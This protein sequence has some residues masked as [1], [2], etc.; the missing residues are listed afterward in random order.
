MWP[1]AGQAGWFGPGPAEQS[2]AV[3]KTNMIADHLR[4]LTFAITDGALP[5][6]KGRG[7]VVRSVLRRAVRQT[8]ETVDAIVTPTTP[9][10][11]PTIAAFDS[12]YRDPAAPNNISDIRRLTL[13]NTSPFNKYGLPAISVPCGFSRNGL[14]IGLQI[15]GAHGGEAVILQ[16]AHAYEQATDWH[17]RRPPIG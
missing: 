17:K 10:S 12:A 13:R 3:R 11:P 14:P 16:L 8:F 7:S 9:I 2:G 1:G 15:T 4:M 6:N 5:S